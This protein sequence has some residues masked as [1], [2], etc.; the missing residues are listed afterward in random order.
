MGLCALL[1]MMTLYES[2]VKRPSNRVD[3]LCFFF[4]CCVLFIEKEKTTV[5]RTC[6]SVDWNRPVMW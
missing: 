4:L 2:V 1:K 6:E 3:K 5:E